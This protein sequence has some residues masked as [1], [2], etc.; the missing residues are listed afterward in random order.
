MRSGLLRGERDG[1]VRGALADARR[2]AH[3]ARAIALER[4]PLVGVHGGDPQIVAQQLVVVLRVRDGR[5]EQLQPRLGGR[6]RG[7]GEDGA[8]LDHVLAADVVADQ[9]GL[10]G[11]RPYVLGLPADEDAR[12]GAAPA[13]ALARLRGGGL[14]DVL[15]GRRG[16]GL[17]LGALGLG[18]L[19]VLGLG[20]HAAA[21]GSRLD[22]GRLGG[23]LVDAGL[24]GRLALRRGGGLLG[25]GALGL[26]LGLLGRR[27]GGLGLG[28][29]GVLGD[30]VLVGLALRRILRV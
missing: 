8:R 21:L 28:V 9:P 17:V 29:L 22:L 27:G 4:R 7:E 5:L 16:S 20:G 25:P 11:R 14:L 19:G 15:L 26:G 1:Q 3:G 18:A 12:L 10:A 30:L 24:L 23:V 2:A 6:A 13:V